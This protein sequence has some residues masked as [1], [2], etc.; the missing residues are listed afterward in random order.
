MSTEESKVQKICNCLYILTND[1]KI[2]PVDAS[3]L[4]E[5]IKDAFTHELRRNVHRTFQKIE[6]YSDVKT[7]VTE[8]IQPCF[9]D[10]CTT[11]DYLK[12]LQ[13]CL[14]LLRL[15]KIALTEESELGSKKSDASKLP[16]PKAL[17]NM[18]QKN[19]L[20]K[21]L[22]F[23]VALG[24]LPNLLRGIGIPLSKRLKH[25]IILERFTSESTL[26]QKHIQI[27]VCLDT[28]IGCLECEA[29]QSTILSCHGTDI[30]AALLQLCHAPIKKIEKTEGSSTEPSQT[31]NSNHS[32]A[33]I[34]NMMLAHRKYFAPHLETFLKQ[35]C[36]SLL[37]WELLLFQGIPIKIDESEAAIAKSPL[38][39]RKIC[40]QMLTDMILQN[41]GIADLVQVVLDKA[42]DADI[43]TG[44][45]DSSRIEAVARLITYN[46]VRHISVGDYIQRLSKQVFQLLH[47]KGSQM[48]GLL[49][50]VASCI[51]LQFCERDI[52]SA[53]QHFLVK[54]LKPLWSCVRQP[55]NSQVNVVVKEIEL[56]TCIEDL[57]QIFAFSSNLLS[58]KYIKL[59][60]PF[61]HCLCNMFFFLL[62][63]KS[64]LKSKVKNLINAILRNATDEEALSLL[65]AVSFSNNKHCGVYITKVSFVNGEEGGIVAVQKVEEDFPDEIVRYHA[66]LDLLSELQ[67]KNLNRSYILLVLKEFCTFHLESKD[68]V[69]DPENIKAGILFN[70]LLQEL[71]E[72]NV[73]IGEALMSNISEVIDILMTLLES[74]CNCRT[75]AT[76]YEKTL[77]VVLMILNSIL[78]SD[79]Q[80]TPAD[81]SSLKKCLPSLKKLQKSDID[82]DL[83]EIIFSI[84]IHIATHGAACKNGIEIVKDFVTNFPDHASVALKPSEQSLLDLVEKFDRECN[85]SAQSIKSKPPSCIASSNESCSKASSSSVKRTQSEK[86]VP[87]HNTNSSKKSSDSAKISKLDESASKKKDSPYMLAMRD[88]R[89]SLVHIKGNGLI[90]LVNLLKEKDEETLQN[91]KEVLKTL[92]KSLEDEDS[93]VYIPAIQALS[94]L[95]AIE[96]DF[97]LPYVLNQYQASE[98]KHIV[99]KL[100]EVLLKICNT[101]GDSLSKY[102]D[103]LLH[104]YLVGT[105]R[106]DPQIRSSSLSNLGQACMCL[107]FQISNHWLQEILN[108][109]LTFLKTDPDLEVRRCAVMVIYLLLKG[110]DKDVLTHIYSSKT[111]SAK[112][113]VW[114]CWPGSKVLASGPKGSRFEALLH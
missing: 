18:S 15:L 60:F 44:K 64:F 28:L 90:S 25:A 3:R 41:Q 88:A 97:V 37:M 29:M 65:H 22:Q 26:Y 106:D 45:V 50:Y 108:S 24:I 63:G 54:L 34:I 10:K 35:I 59:L 74:I 33:Q 11:C 71:S 104:A 99:L 96:P 7:F 19:V 68:N 107:K 111:A 6:N 53:E 49:K 38:W 100:G 98:E 76:F 40:N 46:P 32:E 101:L 112:Y 21:S 39:L 83:K 5:N 92:R 42:Y 84:I 66:I 78:E 67:N 94:I 85:L 105:K 102:K 14:V 77:W 56:T 95:G 23:A 110:L 8:Y 75:D 80:L 2:E 55:T 93:H 16:I 13:L 70:A 72:W 20:Q 103:I 87:K 62:R 31:D 86:G 89:T 91:K 9:G 17:L 30:L 36:P 58:R 73:D 57:H 113:T 1:I 48:D 51:V 27:A 43:R 52:K 114:P 79:D 4:N 109:V 12:F 81:W 47:L 69:M 82:S 61:S